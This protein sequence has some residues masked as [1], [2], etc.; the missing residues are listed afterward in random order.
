M[1]FSLDFD[2]GD[3]VQQRLKLKEMVSN[4]AGFIPHEDA[5]ERLLNSSSSI[6]TATMYQMPNYSIWKMP[7]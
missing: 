4:F 6:E 7:E 1:C 5:M 2:V 3:T